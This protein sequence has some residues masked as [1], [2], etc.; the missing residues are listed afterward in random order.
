[1]LNLKMVVVPVQAMKA[2]SG[3][4]GLW[5]HTFFNSAVDFGESLASRAGR[6]MAGEII[7]LY[8][9]P[10]GSQSSS[11]R[12]EGEKIFASS[13]NLTP[14]HLVHGICIFT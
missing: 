1:M 10:N 11:E 3:S 12:F 8:G 5:L 9:R 2:Y 6:F 14:D 13:G 4:R 7:S